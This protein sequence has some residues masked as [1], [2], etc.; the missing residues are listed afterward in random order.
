VRKKTPAG[1]PAQTCWAEPGGIMFAAAHNGG[2]D[3]VPAQLTS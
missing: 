1:D 3:V 2:S